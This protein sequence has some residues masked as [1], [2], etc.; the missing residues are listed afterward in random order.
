M[1]QQKH[2]FFPSFISHL[3]QSLHRSLTFNLLFV[4]ITLHTS[5]F[6]IGLSRKDQL[7]KCRSKKHS[8][9]SHSFVLF[10][11]HTNF[12]MVLRNCWIWHDDNA[13]NKEHA[14]GFVI[15]CVKL[16]KPTLCVFINTK[17]FT[18]R[19]CPANFL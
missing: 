1:L 7:W 16:M 9:L 13:T 18:S 19:Y 8:K 6:G 15:H 4:F 12:F 5:H 3:C 2:N 11:D 14:S 10:L 17:V